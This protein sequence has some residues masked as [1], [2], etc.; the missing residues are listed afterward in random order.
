MFIF[1]FSA[2]FMLIIAKSLNVVQCPEFQQLLFLLRND[3]Q[4]PLRTKLR[5][6]I[7]QAWGQ[8]FQIL[9]NDLQVCPLPSPIR[10]LIVSSRILWG[11]FHLQLT[12][13]PINAF[14]LI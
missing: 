2:C 11:K 14:S 6:L 12:R 9:R 5:E 3:L 1:F 8:Y 7:I 4:L 10:L 13:G